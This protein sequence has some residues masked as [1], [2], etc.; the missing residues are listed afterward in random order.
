LKRLASILLLL[1][2]LGLGSGALDYLHEL[3]HAREDAIADVRAK[4]DGRPI[5]PHHHDESNCETCAQLHIQFVFVRWVPTLICLGL[6]VAFLT[7]L[8]TPLISRLT[9]ARIDCRGP[10]AV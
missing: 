5:V 9:P 2:F 6:F 10:P 7:L 8:D 4:A 3:Q 1:T